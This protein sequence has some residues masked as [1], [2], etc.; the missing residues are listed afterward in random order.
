M[1]FYRR[2]KHLRTMHT[3]FTTHSFRINPGLLHM[4]SGPILAYRTQPP[5]RS[6]LTAH[7]PHINLGLPHI[8]STSILAYRTQPPH[9]S[10][11]T[12]HSLRI[13]PS[14]PKIVSSG[15]CNPGLR[16]EFRV[17]M[18]VTISA[19]KRCSVRL[20]I[21]LF[22]VGFMSYLCYLCLFAHSGVQHVV[23]CFCFVFRRIVYPMLPVSLDCPF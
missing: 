22:V 1:L 10:W 17:V 21:Q 14:L 4:P 20:Y 19:L 18:S 16:S 11:L 13:N 12:A 6:W 3:C 23:L 8:S 9:Q 2:P 7:S 15:Q 5:H